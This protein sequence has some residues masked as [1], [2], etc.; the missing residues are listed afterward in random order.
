MRGLEPPTSPVSMER[1]GQLSYISIYY[2]PF[3]NG[4]RAELEVRDQAAKCLVK[5]P[6]APTA[7]IEPT[8]L[9]WMPSVLPLYYVGVSMSHHEIG[10]T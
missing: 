1:S 8:F 2:A 5:C 6:E 10:A 3:S 9:G 7:G 4:N